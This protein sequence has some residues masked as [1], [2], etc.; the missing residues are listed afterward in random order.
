MPQHSDR[1][2]QLG[3]DRPSSRRDFLN[4]V[5]LTPGTIAL[6]ATPSFSL[7]A[8]PQTGDP[9]KLTGLRN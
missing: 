4:G 9:A 3:M 1:D 7:S 6:S 8:T 2:K 5:A